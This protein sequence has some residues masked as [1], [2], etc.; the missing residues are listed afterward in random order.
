MKTVYP[1]YWRKRFYLFNCIYELYFSIV[2]LKCISQL[3][4]GG[5][6]GGRGCVL[7]LSR[8]RALPSF[9]PSFFSSSLPHP[10]PFSFF[11]SSSSLLSRL[12]KNS[13]EREDE[14]EKEEEGRGSIKEE[15]NNVLNLSQ[16]QS[17]VPDDSLR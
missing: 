10:L 1:C 12:Q 13:A 15:G 11:S 9:L 16:A 17:D 8:D 4:G 14:G 2:F 6:E 7:Q 5:G 3:C